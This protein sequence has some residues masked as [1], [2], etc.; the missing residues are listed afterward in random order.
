MGTFCGAQAPFGGTGIMGMLGHGHWGVHKHCM[1]M[2]TL[3]GHGHVLGG[4]VTFWGAQA[5]WRGCGH[6]ENWGG[7]GYHVGHGDPERYRHSGGAQATFGGTG[8]MGMLGHGVHKCC[9][10]MGTHGGARG[11]WGGTG[12][13]GRPQTSWGCG[14]RGVLEH[15]GVLTGGGRGTMGT[16][17]L[18]GTQAPGGAPLQSLGANGPDWHRGVPSRTP[19][20]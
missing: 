19:G 2:G 16:W 4:T 12:T 1:S 17:V 11:P 20:C 14:H 3:G 9:R 7:N 5:S 10:S 18:Q 6:H 13:L 8:I 15:P